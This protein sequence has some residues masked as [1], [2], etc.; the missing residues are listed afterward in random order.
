MDELLQQSVMFADFLGKTVAKTYEIIVFDLQNDEC[1]VLSHYNRIPGTLNAARSLLL[2]AMQSEKI[3]KAGYI[4]NRPLNTENKKMV[5]SSIWF[6]KREETVVGAFCLN[7]NCNV[8]IDVNAILADLLSF[9]IGELDDTE[10]ELKQSHKKYVE[11]SFDM[12][13]AIVARNTDDPMRMTANEKFETICDLYDADIFELKGAVPRVAEAIN[14]STQS[15]YRYVA[16]I[17]KA[18]K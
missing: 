11:P 4:L 9:N 8:L 6:V 17:R 5:K 16:E 12:I 3:R 10:E 7:V 13:A 18:R 1:S 14:L 2:E 15:V